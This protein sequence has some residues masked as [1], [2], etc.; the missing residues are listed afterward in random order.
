MNNDKRQLLSIQYLRAV[1][2][3]MVVV[4]HAHN[5]RDWLFNPLEGYYS[6]AWGVDIFFVISGFIMYL[7]ARNEEPLEFLKRRFIRVAPFYWCATVAF[8]MINWRFDF[9]SIPL[10]EWE[11][12]LKSLAFIP[13]YNSL[14]QGYILPYLIPGWTL[15]YEMFFYFIFF[16]AIIS[17]RIIQITSIAILG[18]FITGFLFDFNN[19]IMDTYTKPILLE[20]LVGVWIASIY[21]KGYLRQYTS[22]FLFLGFVGLFVLPAFDG[23]FPLIWGRILFSSFILIGALSYG[24]KVP[25]SSFLKL[26]GDASYSIY[27]THG[28]I[29][30]KIS[31]YLWSQI[32]LE[33]WGQFIGWIIF[34]VSICSVIGILV[35]LYFEKP[36]LSWFNARMRAGRKLKSIIVK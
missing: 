17:G 15:N 33:G 36:L 7:V 5:H 1:A 13:H 28:V 35:H 8:L 9:L 22:L 29:S 12:V 26:L 4:H 34:S 27:L 24:A 3:L 25:H 18:L 14:S 32:P 16:V 6:F 21:I 2:A 11:R 23:Q 10:W 31:R 30:L 20:F 19:P